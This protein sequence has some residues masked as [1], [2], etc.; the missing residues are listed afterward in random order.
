MSETRVFASFRDPSGL[1][2]HH[3]AYADTVPLN[4]PGARLFDE[5]ALVHA[6]GTWSR[7]HER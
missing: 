6:E 1:V 7:D 5:L 3:P 4:R 2:S